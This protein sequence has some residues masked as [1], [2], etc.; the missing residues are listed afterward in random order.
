MLFPSWFL[1][2]CIM[3]QRYW[4]AKLSDVLMWELLR[5]N[6]RILDVQSTSPTT[7]KIRF[8]KHIRFP[9]WY[10][11]ERSAYFEATLDNQENTMTV[12]RYVKDTRRAPQPYIR[13][14]D[15]FYNEKDGRLAQVRHIYWIYLPVKLIEICH[16]SLF[17]A[18]FQGKMLSSYLRPK[19]H[20]NQH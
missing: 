16:L 10:F 11:N 18:R 5:R 20:L 17:W 14:Y 1:G 9:I 12:D 6:V 8:Q 3:K 4:K 2:H 19:L 7:V 15:S 13:E